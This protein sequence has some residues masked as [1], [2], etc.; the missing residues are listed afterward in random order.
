MADPNII[1][2]ARTVLADGSIASVRLTVIDGLIASIEPSAK[3]ADDGLL[4]PAFVDLQVNGVDDLDVWSIARRSD[5]DG[6]KRLEG[7]LLDRG[8]GAWCPT[9]VTAPIDDYADAMRFI[10]TRS[11][12]GGPRNLG[13]H[14]EGPFL[15]SAR[16]AHRSDFVRDPDTDFLAGLPVRPKIVTLGCEHPGA[17]ALIEQLARAGVVVSLGHTRPVRDSYED[18]VSRGATMV[19]HLFN[20]MGGVAHRDPGLATWVLRDPRVVAGLIADGVHVHPDV[21]ALAF[22]CKPGRIALVT[23]SVA[24]RSGRVGD[25]TVVEG[26]APRLADGTLAG[27]SATMSRCIRTCLGAGVPLVEVVRAATTVPARS[28]GRMDIGAIEVG[29]RADLLRLGDDMEP[30]EMWLSGTRVR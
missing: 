2:C 9:L 20:A 5:E 21:I 19:T 12:V 28:V 11:D 23:D 13:V 25:V 7:A 8:I 29:A 24:W 16:G 10:T 26:D 15:G 17:P 1:E 22:D 27:S 4:V 3:A 18:A 30:R 6:W 14:L